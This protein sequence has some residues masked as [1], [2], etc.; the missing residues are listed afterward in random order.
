MKYEII[1]N[2]DGRASTKNWVNGIEAAT[3][4]I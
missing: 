2:E 4:Q 3:R 1:L